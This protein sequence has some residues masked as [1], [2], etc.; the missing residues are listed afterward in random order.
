MIRKLEYKIQEQ[1]NG[2]SVQE[3]LKKRGYSHHI[4][5]ALKKMPE[6]ILRNGVWVYMRDLLKTGEILTILIQETMPSE[7]K[8]VN[9]PLSI[10]Y[11]DEDLLVVDK[12][13]GMAIHPS[14]QH[15]DNTLANA[16]VYYYEKQKIP[17]TFRC[18]NR[19]DRD[20]S[21]L[22]V[23]AKHMLSSHLLSQAVRTRNLHREYLAIADGILP[24]SGV[25]DAPI[26]RKEGSV[27]ER[28]IDP[29]HGER[30]VTHYRTLDYKDGLS[31][32]ALQLE[33][34]R[35]HQIRVHL[36]SIGH[37]LIGDFLYHPQNSKMKRQA[38]H[39]YRLT[40]SHPITKKPLQ[41]TAPMPSDMTAFFNN[42]PAL[43]GHF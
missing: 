2:I 36:Q 18:V 43:E 15:Y 11:E 17:F 23:I 39:S 41:F 16:V 6:S 1:E 8:A 35:T 25:I 33:T 34:G 7:I 28:C 9:L 32:V 14:M 37:P 24:P 31:L 26:A 4:L 21:G 19:L 38:L 3:F 12:P 27:L 5:T 40:F 30:A 29:V 10:V 42:P 22:T 20:T 13:A